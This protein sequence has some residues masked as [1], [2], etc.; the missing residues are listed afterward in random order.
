ME[1]YIKMLQEIVNYIENNYEDTHNL[2][3]II[4]LQIMNLKCLELKNNPLL[5]IL[6]DNMISTLG[7]MEFKNID[8][9]TKEKY[10]N[11]ILELKNKK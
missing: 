2:P 8:T 5:D 3:M 10:K 7:I 11:I 9:T 6:I 1:N 4:K